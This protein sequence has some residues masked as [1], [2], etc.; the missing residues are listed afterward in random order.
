MLTATY[1]FITERLIKKLSCL[2]FNSSVVN[3]LTH[4]RQYQ[5]EYFIIFRE[6]KKVD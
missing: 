3:I 5:R 2:Q 1:M 4:G 6:V